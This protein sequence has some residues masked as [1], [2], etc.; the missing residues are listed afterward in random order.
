MSTEIPVTYYENYPIPAGVSIIPYERRLFGLDSYYGQSGEEYQA[1]RKRIIGDAEKKGHC[2]IFSSIKEMN[3]FFQS[4]NGRHEEVV[5]MKLDGLREVISFKGVIACSVVILPEKR[6]LYKRCGMSYI[7]D[8]E[9]DGS[10][11][12]CYDFLGCSCEG[13]LLLG[14]TYVSLQSLVKENEN[15]ADQIIHYALELSGLPNEFFNS[16]GLNSFSDFIGDGEKT[17]NNLIT[18]RYG[19]VPFPA[20]TDDGAF[21]RMKAIAIKGANGNA[22]QATTSYFKS[23]VKAVLALEDPV[24]GFEIFDVGNSMYALSNSL[25]KENLD[26]RFETVGDIL[27][28]VISFFDVNRVP[29]VGIFNNSNGGVMTSTG[30]NDITPGQSHLIFPISAAT[31]P[32]LQSVLLSY[33]IWAVRQGLLSGQNNFNEVIGNAIPVAMEHFQRGF[34]LYGGFYS[35]QLINEMRAT[36]EILEDVV[37][38]AKNMTRSKDLI[39][40]KVWALS[41]TT[42]SMAIAMLYLLMEERMSLASV[43]DWVAYNGQDSDTYLAA[44]APIISALFRKQEYPYGPL[45]VDGK[46]ALSFAIHF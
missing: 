30:L 40:G 23:F 3:A 14:R 44:A 31:H 13:L 4:S 1:F 8:V 10:F 18:L 39:F 36:R 11:T 37:A 25:R 45:M 22:D 2:I 42:T 7:S 34:K 26:E 12:F 35:E 27:S 5:K 33:F 38:E 15:L 19:G 16:N 29:G 17:C 24:S 46:L 20:F 41:T 21:A 28:Y 6:F 32:H 9:L 43:V